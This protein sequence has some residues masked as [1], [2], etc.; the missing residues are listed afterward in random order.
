MKKVLLNSIA[1]LCLSLSLLPSQA[2]AYDPIIFVHGF[3][4]STVVNFT[5]M[6][7]RFK[8]AGYPSDHLHYYTYNTLP[9]VAN[10]AEILKKKVAEVM[11]KTGKSKVDIISHSM[12]GLVSR[13]Y[14]KKLGGAKNIDQI[15]NIATPHKGTIW[16]NLVP[17]TQ[18]TRDMRPGSPLLNSISGY[19]P[20][21][22]LWSKCDEIV[23][24]HSSARVG[25]SS[26]IGCWG[27]LSSTYSWGVFK[28]ARDFVAP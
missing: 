10:G 6:I 18:A 14:M 16:A 5:S 22:N 23:I 15:V 26:G 25:N 24:P 28:K 2:A 17:I 27:H 21:L 19:Y 1:S 4:G 3:V 9:G 11:K 8:R 7:S 12:G 13:Y 20:G